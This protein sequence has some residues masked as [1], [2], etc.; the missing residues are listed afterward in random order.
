VTDNANLSA[1]VWRLRAKQLAKNFLD[2]ILPP[3]C[4]HCG[5]AGS[6]LCD[7]CL[8]GLPRM[9]GPL[10]SLC[11][12]MVAQPTS[13]CFACRQYHLPLCQ[14]RAAVPFKEAVPGLIHKM[15]YKGLFAL[16]EPLSLV[17]VESWPMWPVPVDLVLPI[18][19]HPKRR[20]KRGYNQAELLANH[21]CHQLQLPSEPMALRR[22]RD[23]RPQ[24]DLNTWAR[25]ANVAGAFEAE[26]GWVRGKS[27]VL[28]D[29]VCTTGSTLSAAASALLSAGAQTVSGYCLARAT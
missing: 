11:G 16:T 2:L 10:C 6:L 5:Q 12:R 18:P 24:V 9:R 20:Q 4:A 26:R 19:L 22:V 17:M 13:C 23:T 14:I 1:V 3:I 27:I 29:D 25:Q 7:D 28:I 21:L 8:A 15:K